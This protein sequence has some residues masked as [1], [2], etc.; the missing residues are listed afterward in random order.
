MLT[1]GVKKGGRSFVF[2]REV[3]GLEVEELHMTSCFNWSRG[4]SVQEMG[5][6]CRVTKQGTHGPDRFI[7]TN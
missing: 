5:G 6:P 4:S 2:L 3:D 1:L 7:H